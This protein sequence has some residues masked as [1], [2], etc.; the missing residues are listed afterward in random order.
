MH[1][2]DINS[3]IKKYE[4]QYEIIDE[5]FVNRIDFYNDR[6]AYILNKLNNRFN[7]LKNLMKFI[8]LILNGT[9]VIN[10][11]PMDKILISLE[12]NKLDKIEDSYNYLLSIPLYKLSKEELVKL[13]NEFNDLKSEIQ[14]IVET[15]IEKMWHQDL[16]ELKKEVRR[17]RKEI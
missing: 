11:I 15:P 2:F 13:K 4:N 5:Y 8:K 12:T 9:I 7:H 14:T 17:F 16:L 1:L 3:K 10:N 6:K